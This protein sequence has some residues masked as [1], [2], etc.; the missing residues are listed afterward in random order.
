MSTEEEIT[1]DLSNDAK[2]EIDTAGLQETDLAKFEAIMESY[3]EILTQLNSVSLT[4]IFGEAVTF[5]EDQ[6]VSYI[7]NLLRVIE[8]KVKEGLNNGAV[9][10]IGSELALDLVLEFYTKAL[11]SI[12][13]E[14]M[15]KTG[16][17]EHIIDVSR[18]I[19]LE[20]MSD[21]EGEETTDETDQ[22]KEEK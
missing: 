17:P 15:Q 14:Y 8:G 22:P 21:I 18:N 16:L 4:I 19:I 13:S 2:Y 20:A 1:I 10:E 9:P 12:F 6:S 11:N 5:V 3:Q 7:N